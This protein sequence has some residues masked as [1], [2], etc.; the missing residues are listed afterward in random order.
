MSVW[1]REWGRGSWGEQV[2]VSVWRRE[3]AQARGTSE[4]GSEGGGR[5]G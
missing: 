1:R 3:W 5:S 4:W 2:G